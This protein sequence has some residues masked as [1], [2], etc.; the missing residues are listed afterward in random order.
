MP[1][2]IFDADHLK[3][4]TAA[5]QDQPTPELMEQLPA[6]TGIHGKDRDKNHGKLAFEDIVPL[7]P[8]LFY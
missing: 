4:L 5:A 1:S 7:F 3:K 2:M 8:L 6:T